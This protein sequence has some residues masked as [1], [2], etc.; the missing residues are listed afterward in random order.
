MSLI[1]MTALAGPKSLSAVATNLIPASHRE[2]QSLV[3][4]LLATVKLSSP[5]STSTESANTPPAG[6]VS[7]QSPQ[8]NSYFTSPVICR[9]L[10]SDE[11]VR[12]DR[13][14]ASQT[15]SDVST[16]RSAAKAP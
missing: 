15:S 5:G 16:P 13:P 14:R 4:S 2:F 10:V 1:L 6:S 7:A 3:P 8:L 11:I 12:P 9:Q